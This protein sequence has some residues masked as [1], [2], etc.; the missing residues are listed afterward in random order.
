MASIG[1]NDVK[2]LYRGLQGIM[3]PRRPR[4]A[5]LGTFGVKGLYSGSEEATEIGPSLASLGDFYDF[6]DVFCRH[7]SWTEITVMGQGGPNLYYIEGNLHKYTFREEKVKR[8]V[9][10][11]CEEFDSEVLN[12]FA[13]KHRLLAKE[14]RVDLSDEFSPDYHGDAFDYLK[15]S[16]GTRVW[17]VIVYDPPFNER[18]SKE[19]YEGRRVGKYTKMKDSI[20]SCLNVGGKI[21]GLGHE[22]SNFGKI[23]GMEIESLYVINPFGEIR[24]YFISV[25]RKQ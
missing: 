9:E 20:V 21:I 15:D 7:Q 1:E 18:K 17:D 13:G 6:C 4:L 3:W 12:L 24:P 22:I 16:I 19:F 5:I 8:A 10:I 23:R 14:F 25:E 2:G 11:E